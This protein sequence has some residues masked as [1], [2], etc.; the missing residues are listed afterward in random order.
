[1]I[2]YSLEVGENVEFCL[3]VFSNA[4]GGRKPLEVCFDF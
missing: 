4:A 1:M 2:F 3:V